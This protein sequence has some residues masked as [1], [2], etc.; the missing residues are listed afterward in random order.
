MI[1][2][3]HRVNYPMSKRNRLQ[4]DLQRNEWLLVYRLPKAFRRLKHSKRPKHKQ[5]N[6]HR[7]EVIKSEDIECS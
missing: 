2:T 5:V 1:M 3:K 6:R 4:K 7:R